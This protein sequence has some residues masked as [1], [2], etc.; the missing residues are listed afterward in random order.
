MEPLYAPRPALVLDGQRR[1]EELNATPL[2]QD[3]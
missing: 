2:F 1:G 3:L